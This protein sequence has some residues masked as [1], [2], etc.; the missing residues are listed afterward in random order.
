MLLPSW[1]EAAMCFPEERRL[2][3][4]S[5]SGKALARIWLN[6]EEPSHKTPILRQT[7]VIISGAQEIACFHAHNFEV[8]KFTGIKGKAFACFSAVSLWT[9]WFWLHLSDQRGKKFV[10]WE[11]SCF[12]GCTEFQNSTS[13]ISAEQNIIFYHENNII[14]KAITVSP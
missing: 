5:T 4:L 14:A 9:S 3:Q 7:N 2:P 1:A 10:N 13:V 6:K 11:K 8:Q 12:V